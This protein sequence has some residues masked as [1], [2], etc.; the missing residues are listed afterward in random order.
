[1][2]TSALDRLQKVW[3]AASSDQSRIVAYL[4]HRGLPDDV[5]DGMSDEVLRFHGSLAYHDHDEAGRLV[6]IGRY[7]AMVAAVERGA[8]ETVTL[9]RTYL[10]PQDDGKAPVDSPKKLMSTVADGATNGAAIRL[11]PAGSVLGLAEGIETALAVRAATG[12]AV[13]A[14][15]SAGG[16]ERVV[17]PAEVETVHL[18]ADNDRSRTGQHAALT[19][20]KRLYSEGRAVYVHLPKK[21]GTDWLDVYVGSGAGNLLG[22]VAECD[23]WRPDAHSVGVLL[24]TVKPER[25][26][27]LWERRIP[28]G[29]VTIIDGDPRTG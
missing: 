5:L 24:S 18:W 22:E 13:W 2:G 3:E 29:K 20:A 7:P 21:E 27:W 8:G 15:V 28:L 23:S 11:F 9:H 19:A 17:L 4:R 10:H 26:E 6:L 14:C 1:M 12:Q 25:V 16:L